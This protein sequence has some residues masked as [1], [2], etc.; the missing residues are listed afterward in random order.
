MKKKKET[1]NRRTDMRVQCLQCMWI[2]WSLS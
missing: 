2:P 1:L